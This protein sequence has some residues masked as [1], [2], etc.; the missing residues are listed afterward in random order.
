VGI[1]THPFLPPSTTEK[2]P[3]RFY[4]WVSEMVVSKVNVC[5][6]SKGKTNTGKGTF[7]GV[8][9]L[10]SLSL[11][12]GVKVK[13][14]VSVSVCVCVCVCACARLCTPPVRMCLCV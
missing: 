9:I 10:S 13:Q 12:K 14:T 1:T 11:R 4:D 2:D 3:L 7:T 6:G 8:G 5:P